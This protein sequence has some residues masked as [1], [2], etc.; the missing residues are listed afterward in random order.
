[1]TGELVQLAKGSG[2][3]E[4][5]VPLLIMAEGERAASRYIEFFTAQVR[6]PNTRSAYIRA[7][8]VFFAWCEQHGLPLTAI[9]PVHVATYIE[10]IGRERSAPTV[11]Q[12]LAA[13]RMLFDWLVIG[14]VVPHNPAGAV[15]GPKHSI[16]T[17]KTHMPSREEARSLLAAIDTT[18]LIGLRDRALIGMLLYTFARVSATTAMRV[19]DYY[20]VGK[21]WWVRLHEKGDKEHTIPAH[22]TLQNWLDA[23]LE[24]A[25]IAEDRKGLLFR[26]AAGRTGQLTANGMSQADAYRM[27]QRRAEAGGV[28]TRIGCHS[29]RARGITAYLENG[30]LLEHAQQMA[31]HASARTTKL[32]DRRGQ[33]ITLDEVERITL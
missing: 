30:G 2:L 13:I 28:A 16:S 25:A 20:P 32:Y 18:S 3:A 8:S 7:A 29:W 24:A 11:K 26:S 31:A 23:Y 9:Q 21:R 10:Q 19:S 33:Q 17:G 14:Q 6:N 15:R 12:H 1:M 4:L 27:I 22:H 5:A